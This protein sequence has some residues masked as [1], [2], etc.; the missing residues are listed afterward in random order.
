[1]KKF[2]LAILVLAMALPLGCSNVFEKSYVK[3][4]PGIVIK[5]LPPEPINQIITFTA[6]GKGV[7]PES[8][9]TKGQAIFLAERAAIDDGYRRLAEKLKGV[10]IEAYSK[11]GLGI[12]EQNI[13]ESRVNTI[14][15][16]VNIKQVYIG[17]YGIAEA[18]MELRV[19]FTRYGMIWWPAGL[20]QDSES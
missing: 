18:I 2:C 3:T 17:E 9:I 19:K 16:G 8:A 4:S 1:M 5:N 6:I 10:Y 12:V 14:I 11:A 13:L 7:Q 15:R 20:S